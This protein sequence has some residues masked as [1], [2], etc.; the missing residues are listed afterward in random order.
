MP[1]AL[2]EST[3]RLGLKLAAGETAAGTSPAAAKLAGDVSRSLIMLKVRSVAA[4]LVAAGG[5]GL[6]ATLALRPT[7]GAQ[8][9]PAKALALA[10]QSREPADPFPFMHEKARV[11]NARYV[12]I[13][14]MRPLIKDGN[15]VRF[16]SRLAV[17]SKDGTATLWSFEQKDPV[18]PLLRHKG[19]I[20]E[21]TFFD[22]ANL[23]ITTSDESVKVWDALSGAFRKELEGQSIWPMW[24]SFAP[25]AKRFVTIET[26]HK[27]VTVW[28]AATLE[29][30][31]IF[32]PQGSPRGF[33]VG[34]SGDGRTVVTFTFGAD[35]SAELWD[36]AAARPFATLRPPSPAVAEVFDQGG[37][38]L[39]KS[40][41][42][43][44]AGFWEVVRSLAPAGRE[45]KE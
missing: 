26:G 16:Q 9:P 34:L 3:A 7:A 45:R 24:L 14:N 5:I 12:E 10:G 43:R 38:G 17:L 1:V 21:L 22:E 15:G 30:V 8:P 40:N 6:V 42:Q 25:S 39:N 36:V 20:R 18:A 23:L 41:V 35:P 13:G 29:P 31:A 11:K 4:A 32:R 27:A 37:Q 19:P 2:A 33:S 44:D 28:D